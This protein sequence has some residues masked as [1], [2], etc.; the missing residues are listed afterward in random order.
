MATGFRDGREAGSALEGP[1]RR[2]LWD[3][4][5]TAMR[6]LAASVARSG[7]RRCLSAASSTR[8]RSRWSATCG[9]TSGRTVDILAPD[10]LTPLSS[11]C[12]DR[13][14]P[15]AQTAFVSLAGT[16]PTDGCR[17]RGGLRAAAS[18]RTQAG[19]GGRAV[20]PST[21]PSDGGGARRHRAAPTAPRDSVLEAALPHARAPGLLGTFGFERERRHHR[22]PGHDHAGPGRGAET[23]IQSVE[24]SVVARVVRPRSSLVR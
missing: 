19:G 23:T 21:P 22:V 17:P 13:A 12:H 20:R 2:D 11:S 4:R 18:P 15:S 6:R 24:G 7:G 10:G 16:V 5:A 1:R 14:G 8:M 3:P 9:P